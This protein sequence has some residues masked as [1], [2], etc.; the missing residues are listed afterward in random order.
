MGQL[1]LTEEERNVITSKMEEEMLMKSVEVTSATSEA[2]ASN[3][4]HYPLF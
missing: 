3:V 2:K 4:N 1:K